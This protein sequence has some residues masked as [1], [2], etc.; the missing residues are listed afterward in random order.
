VTPEDLPISLKHVSI[1]PRHNAAAVARSNWRYAFVTV[2]PRLDRRFGNHP[3]VL[4]LERVDEKGQFGARRERRPVGAS[5]RDVLTIVETG[6][7]DH[8]ASRRAG[9]ERICR[10]RRLPRFASM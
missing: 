8:D 6:D 7:F 4:R 9:A 2:I 3:G 5:A 1:C 10:P